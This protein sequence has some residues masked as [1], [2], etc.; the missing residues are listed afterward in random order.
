MTSV[1][2]R[3]LQNTSQDRKTTV[4]NQLPLVLDLSSPY[5]N[6]T[7]N[8]TAAQNKIFQDTAQKTSTKM[9]AI[10]CGEFGTNPL[11]KLE[12]IFKPYDFSHWK[13]S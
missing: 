1:L 10:R 3:K 5:D 8:L 13:M 6:L 12:Q 4:K 2:Y 7:K 11:A 9:N